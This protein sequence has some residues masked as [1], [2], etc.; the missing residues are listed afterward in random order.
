MTIHV[1]DRVDAV[2]ITRRPRTGRRT[3]MISVSSPSLE[4]PQPVRPGGDVRVVLPVA[5]EDVTGGPGAI[6]DDD[7]TRIARFVKFQISRGVED[8]II[9]CDA[10]IS[11]SAGVAVAVAEY[12]NIPI[13]EIDFA[14]PPD[15]NPTV[16]DAVLRALRATDE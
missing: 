1:R 13:S 7:A 14:E 2:R 16:R 11:R 5:F 6:S 10:G 9:H 8:L 4:Y 3:V 15:P 12:L